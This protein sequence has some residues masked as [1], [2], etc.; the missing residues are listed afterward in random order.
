L[1]LHG[2]R[3]EPVRTEALDVLASLAA[4]AAST[5]KCNSKVAFDRLIL[6]RTKIRDQTKKFKRAPW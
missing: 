6:I 1:L 3:Y 5:R 4:S 2:T